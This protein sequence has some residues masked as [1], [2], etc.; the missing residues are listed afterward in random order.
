M[1]HHARV[2]WEK[3]PSET[4]TDRKYSRAHRWFFDG[5]VEIPASSSPSVVPIPMSDES[6]VDPEE[7]FTAAVSSCHML[8]FL[9]IAAARKYVIDRYEDNAEGFMAKNAEG[10]LAIESVTLKP[11]IT[12]AG[13]A[14]PSETQIAEMHE[15]A[16]AEC[17]IANS[18]RSKVIIASR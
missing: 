4:F 5:G 10:K 12:F 3:K 11:V 9:S 6:A 8:T 18:I 17:F 15:A 1:K 16:H 14:K 13:M 7:A 2:F